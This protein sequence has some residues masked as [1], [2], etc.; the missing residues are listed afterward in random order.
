MSIIIKTEEQIDGIRKSCHLAVDTIDFLEEYIKPGV[1][2]NQLNQ[3][4]DDFIK[5]YNGKSAALG[6]NGFPKSICTS[7]NDVICHGIPSDDN[8]LKEGDVLKI[9]VC[10]ILNGF[11]GDTCKTFIVG[12]SS[13]EIKKLVSTAKDCLDIGVSKVKPNTCFGEIGKA[14]SNYANSKSFSVVYQFVGHGVGL[15]LHENPAVNHDDSFYNKEL[16]L[17]GMVFTIEPMINQYKPDA[18]IM[19]DR[20]TAKTV[21]F[22]LSAQ[23]EHTVL[24]TE[25]GV[26]VLTNQL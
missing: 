16:M 18:V 13:E 20:W 15:Q 24:V 3:L 5:K 23:F 7:L 1:S 2:T 12:E 19:E 14:I 17:P 22:G 10:T 9:D 25:T 6:Y 26:D 21:D 8:I 4:A 11:F